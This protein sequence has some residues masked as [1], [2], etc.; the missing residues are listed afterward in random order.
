MPVRVRV[1][2]PRSR[3][4]GA[5]DDGTVVV[6]CRFPSVGDRVHCIQLPLMLCSNPSTA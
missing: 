3:Q 2:A 1:A 5:Y 6:V 4:S